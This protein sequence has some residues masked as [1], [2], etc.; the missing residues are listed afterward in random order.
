[1]EIPLAAWLGALVGTVIGVALYMAALGFIDRWLR[2]HD[3]PRTMEERIEFEAMLAT[4]RRSI[5]A[6]DIAICAS[7]GYWIGGALAA[8]AHTGAPL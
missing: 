6:L 5:L 3:R 4:K 1:M 8:A 7:I 2:R